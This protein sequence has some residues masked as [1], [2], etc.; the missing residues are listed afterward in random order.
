MQ[1]S[2]DLVCRTVTRGSTE[3]SRKTSQNIIRSIPCNIATASAAILCCRQGSLM[4]GGGRSMRSVVIGCVSRVEARAW[5]PWCVA[6]VLLAAP[7]ALAQS[8][9]ISGVVR[10]PQQ[11]VVPGAQVV[12]TM[13]GRLPGR[14]PSPMARAVTA[15]MN[16]A[17]DNY[18]VEVHAKGFQVI[19]SQAIALASG[20]SVD[21]RFR[22]GARRGGRVGDGH[23]HWRRR[24]RI[25]GRHRQL[26]RAAGQRRRSWTRRTR[27]ASC[28]AS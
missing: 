1:S 6:F 27:S 18:V 7:P 16:L 12:L 8:R 10:D 9:G 15:F 22:V 20:E 21:S 28:R 17:P 25:P 11:A 26:A 4:P 3:V 24:S 2:A 13:R 14:R 19:T 23:G 5:A